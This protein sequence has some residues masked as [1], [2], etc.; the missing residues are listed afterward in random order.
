MPL[1]PRGTSPSKILCLVL[2]VLSFIIPPH[3]LFG[4]HIPLERLL[5]LGVSLFRH[6]KRERRLVIAIVI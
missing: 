3:A 2:I 5:I 1:S 4:S 6:S